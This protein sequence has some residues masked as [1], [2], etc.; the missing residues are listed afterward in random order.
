MFKNKECQRI[1]SAN[2]LKTVKL[3]P[4]WLY[5]PVIPAFERQRR[6]WETQPNLRLTQKLQKPG[7]YGVGKNMNY[8][9]AEQS[10]FE[11]FSYTY[12]SS[13]QVL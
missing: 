2:L 12:D 8:R 3:R 9:S 4:G 7:Q 11:A 10:R 13:I 5:T 6:G 1:L